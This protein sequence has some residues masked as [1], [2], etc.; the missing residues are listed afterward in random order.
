[1]FHEVIVAC[2]TPR[3]WK[4]SCDFRFFQFWWLSC[5]VEFKVNDRI[6]LPVFRHVSYKG[7]IW[8]ENPIEHGSDMKHGSHCGRVDESAGA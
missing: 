5:P 4:N 8:C 3:R 7:K 6:Q 2:E 1:M